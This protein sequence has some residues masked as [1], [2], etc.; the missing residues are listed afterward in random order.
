M[1]KKIKSITITQFDYIIRNVTDEEVDIQGH[2]NHYSEYDPEGHPLKEVKYDRRGNF[3]EMITYEYDGTGHLI[4][5]TYYP[6]EN[7]AA[8]KK[9]FEYD[10]SGQLIHAF[11]HYLDNSVDTIDYEYDGAGQLIKKTTHN[12]D[13]E[14]EQVEKFTWEE[15]KLIR[16]E[17]FDDSGES[18]SL[19]EDRPVDMKNTR[20]TRNEKGMVIKEV[21]VNDQEEILSTIERIYDEED[22]AL[23]TRV[24][25]DGRGE[26][27]SRHYF[28]KY[29]YS[30]FES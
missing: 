12:E 3:E 7:E 26:S 11:K 21:E 6:E 5:E 8:E 16:E 18:L 25:M 13:G 10:G 9:T 28:L 29:E 24:W 20:I 17:I 1:K 14:I 22:R 15:G 4:C 23:E 2:P 27:F 19:W 30:F